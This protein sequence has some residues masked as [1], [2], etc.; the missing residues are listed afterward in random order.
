[1]ATTSMAIQSRGAQKEMPNQTLYCSNL[2]DKL[3]KA[4]LKRSLYLL[5]VTY[6]PVLDIVALKTSKMRGQAHIVF[7][8]IQAASQAMRALQGFEF[9]GKNMKI[10][11]GKGKS[12]S[13]AKLDGTFKI[14]VMEKETEQTPLQQM[15][16]GGLPPGAEETQSNQG[17][18]RT[19]DN[20]S[21]NEDAPMEEDDDD[22][23][24]EESDSD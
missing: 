8:D 17:T 3:Q 5:F 14:P 2:P 15:A 23:A 10:A 24:M 18:K 13:I 12:D 16:F 19:R 11:Y 4:D 7:R 9:F 21:D 22:A 6:G 20:E 1:M